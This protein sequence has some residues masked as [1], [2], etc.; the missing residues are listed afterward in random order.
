MISYIQEPT[1]DQDEEEK[2]SVV[3]NVE[4]ACIMKFEM[5]SSQMII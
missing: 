1:V 4:K 5:S 2:K 3:E